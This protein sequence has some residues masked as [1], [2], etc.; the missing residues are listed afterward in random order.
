M[1]GPPR[2]AR[3]SGPGR[4][5][6]VFWR[7]CAA[8]AAAAALSGCS[9]VPPEPMPT[10]PPA[11]ASA[12]PDGG[13]LLSDLGFRHAPAGFSLPATS[14]LTET[15]DSANNVTAVLSQPAADEV[16]GYLRTHLPAMGFEVTADADGSLLF[17]SATHQG[18]FTST[19]A[20]SAVTLRTDREE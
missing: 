4:L 15:V 10:D 9:A 11:A 8:L 14:V 17:Q 6:P 7:I 18:A 3:A 19:D 1:P 12:A 5:K 13:V 16:L 2:P 20:V